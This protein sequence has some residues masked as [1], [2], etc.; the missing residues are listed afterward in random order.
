MIQTLDYEII[1]WMNQLVGS[2]ATLDELAVF[3]TGATLM[4]MGPLLALVV[5]LWADKDAPVRRRSEIAS[6]FFGAFL[7]LF[8]ARAL[9]EVIVRL[10]PLHE[11]ESLRLPSDMLRSTLD[12]RSSFPSDT[13]TL[14]IAISVI[15]FLQSRRLGMLAFAWSIVFVALPRLYTGLH[16]LSD[17]VGAAV[18]ATVLVWGATRLLSPR[19]DRLVALG[20]RWP[21]LTA[22]FAFLMLFAMGTMFNDV[23]WMGRIIV[24]AL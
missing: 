19:A 4:K 12:G 3:A 13:G 1:L 17:I 22:M 2:Y 15:V 20:E 14:A 9:Q 8:T 5:Y 18:L 16:Y 6:G 10:R 23:R 24:E 11:I 21:G 7:A